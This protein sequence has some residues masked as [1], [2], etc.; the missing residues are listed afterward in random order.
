MLS[1]L[2]WN[3]RHGGGNRIH[4]I[5][6]SLGKHSE[7]DI[8]VL[9]EFRNNQNGKLIQK[10]L[11][12][13]NFKFQYKA[14]TLP[15]K[16]SVLIACKEKFEF[17]VFEELQNHSERV[18]KIFNHKFTLYGCY[19]PNGKDKKIVFEFLL[20]EI[21]NNSNIIITGDINTGKHYIDEKKNTFLHSQYLDKFEGLGMCDAWRYIHENKT[22]YSWYSNMQNGFRLDHFFVSESLKSQIKSCEYLHE[23]REEKVSDHSVMGLG[24]EV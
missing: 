16:N 20:N 22:E 10:F 17:K 24:V 23:Y 7:V 3:L 18:V 15:T 2:T 14:D 5:T 12:N 9:T 4:K 13:L 11:E 19:F 21:K 6:E 8:L 1:I